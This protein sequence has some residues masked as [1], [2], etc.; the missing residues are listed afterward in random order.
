MSK[1]EHNGVRID[2]PI[3]TVDEEGGENPSSD[4]EAVAKVG[5]GRDTDV[6]CVWGRVSPERRWAGSIFIWLVK[7]ND[8]GL[9]G[10]CGARVSGQPN[11]GGW[12]RA[13]IP[14]ATLGRCETAMGPWATCCGSCMPSLGS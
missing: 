1:V 7:R 13:C 5:V 8:G 10:A 11:R 14:A 3:K 12:F 2:F 4:E 9:G 6:A